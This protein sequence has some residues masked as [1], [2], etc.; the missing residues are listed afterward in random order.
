[1]PAFG[2]VGFLPFMLS[3]DTNRTSGWEAEQW[4]VST[5]FF[6][7]AAGAKLTLAIPMGD[8]ASDCAGAMMPL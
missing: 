1:M 3:L 6:S 8:A 5:C 4:E 7:V 2:L